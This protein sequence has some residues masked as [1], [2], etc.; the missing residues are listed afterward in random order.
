VRATQRGRIGACRAK[1]LIV[2]DLLR[3]CAKKPLSRE[4]S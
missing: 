1:A 4:L 3:R 2:E